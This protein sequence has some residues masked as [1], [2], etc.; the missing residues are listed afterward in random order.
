MAFIAPIRITIAMNWVDSMHPIRN[1]HWTVREKKACPKIPGK[2]LV[3]N[4]VAAR[5]CGGQ[6]RRNDAGGTIPYQSFIFKSRKAY[7]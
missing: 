3:C 1:T 5:G 6:P 2:L 4:L 7:P